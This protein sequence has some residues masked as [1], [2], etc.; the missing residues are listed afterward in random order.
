MTRRPLVAPCVRDEWS[1][2]THV[3]ILNTHATLLTPIRLNCQQIY[4]SNFKLYSLDE[5]NKATIN[6]HV[7]NRALS[8]K[9]V[10]LS[11]CGE[12]TLRL[13]NECN[14]TLIQRLCTD[15]GP[16]KLVLVKWLN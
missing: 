6:V 9:K 2:D 14:V 11:K 1:V 10:T 15:S 5:Y 3:T 16:F 13:S 12:K 4:I 7:A 8:K